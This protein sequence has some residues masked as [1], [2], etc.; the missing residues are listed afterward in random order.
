[1][2]GR[3]NGMKQRLNRVMAFRHVWLICIYTVGLAASLWLAYQLRFD[4]AVPALHSERFRI[5]LGWIV[6][7]QMLLLLGFRQ[8]SGKLTVFSTPD[9]LRLFSALAIGFGLVYAARLID[10]L[11]I[12]PPRG[13]IVADFTLSLVLL[14]AFRLC[15]RMMWERIREP[16]T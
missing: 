4:F 12:T 16:H 8:C 14:G 6:P 15:F 13:V 1:M 2:E 3:G 7:L 5:A 9:L 10:T 11:E